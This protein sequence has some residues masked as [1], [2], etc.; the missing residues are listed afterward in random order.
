MVEVGFD[1]N[2]T[3][4]RLENFADGWLNKLTGDSCGRPVD[5]AQL[6]DG[7]LLVSDD[8]AGDIYRIS[9]HKER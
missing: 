5:V 4:T 2:G 3:I 8:Y 7:S 6:R 9:Y 1:G